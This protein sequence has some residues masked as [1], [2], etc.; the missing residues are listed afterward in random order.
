MAPQ[1]AMAVRSAG[2]AR[3]AIAALGAGGQRRKSVPSLAAVA[4]G[5][6]PH[7]A[8]FVEERKPA[9][10][11]GAAEYQATRL[12]AVPGV[13]GVLGVPGVPGDTDCADGVATNNPGRAPRAAGAPA[14]AVA[15]RPAPAA[16]GRPGVAVRTAAA[17]TGK[18]GVA[19]VTAATDPADRSRR[20]IENKPAEFAFIILF[21]A[22]FF[23]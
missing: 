15:A 16:V 9:G 23:F 11:K 4:G 6:Q 2:A 14:A 17:V 19:T 5:E 3:A 18:P 8:E 12:Y 13:L 22:H 1:A 7:L 10:A 21:R 20:G